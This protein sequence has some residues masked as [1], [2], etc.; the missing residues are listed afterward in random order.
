MKFEYDFKQKRIKFESDPE[1]EQDIEFESNDTYK[2]LRIGY[3]SKESPDVEQ[4]KS[5]IARIINFITEW[6]ALITT[7]I[8]PSIAFVV[9]KFTDKLKHIPNVVMYVIVLVIAAVIVIII[10]RKKNKNDSEQ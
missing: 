6:K 9:G 5:L 2:R 8:I 4:P 1:Y 7:I 3:N 10:Y